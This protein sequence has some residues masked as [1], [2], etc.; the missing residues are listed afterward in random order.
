MLKS[1]FFSL[2]L[3]MLPFNAYALEPMP[4]NPPGDLLVTV[5]IT[6]SPEFI[7]EWIETPPSHAPT[8]KRINE[9]KFNQMVHAGFAVTGF[10]KGSDSKV[11]FVVA[12]Q[13]K[14]PD[15]TILMQ[16]NQWASHTKKVLIDKGVIIADPVLDMTFEPSDP[17]GNY[18]ISAIVTDKL[19]GK[20]ASGS[21]I[22][23]IN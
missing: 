9:A 12:V 21:A 4:I 13:V 18:K 20:R 10:T 14:A 17:A 23:K 2:A 22:L 16:E 3:V 19:S 7:K 5:F 8:I 11:N 15:G 1:I 6:D